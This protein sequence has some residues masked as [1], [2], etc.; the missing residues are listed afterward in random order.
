[1]DLDCPADQVQP[2][3][4]I[5]RASAGA[6]DPEETCS[7]SDAACPADVGEPDADADGV[8]DSIDACPTESDP[9]QTDGDADGLGDACDPCTNV[10]PVF[11]SRSKIRIKGLDTP[12]GDDGFVFKGTMTVPTTPPIDPAANGIRLLLDDAGANVLD[13]IVPGGAGWKTSRSG[14][15]WRYRNAAGPGGIVRV[16]LKHRAKTPG[17]LK[18]RVVGRS[19]SL[20]VTRAR[21]PVKGTLVVDTP[22]AQTGQCGETRYDGGRCRFSRS[23]RALRCR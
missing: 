6:C 23:G 11:A 4:F 3:T 14:N 19:E 17:T 13:V 12:P 7:G 21:V 9:T 15:S 20:P 8:C 18:F 10:V 2:A 1:M 22:L 16:S 5:C